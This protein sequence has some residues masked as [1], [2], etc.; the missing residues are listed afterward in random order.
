MPVP[1]YVR[2][3][4]CVRVRVCVCGRENSSNDW[5]KHRD[6]QAHHLNVPC[7]LV[8]PPF[9]HLLPT[10]CLCS[11]PAKA[12]QVWTKLRNV[13]AVGDAKKRPVVSAMAARFPNADA[14]K[15]HSAAAAPKA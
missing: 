9:Q 12:E 13:Q 3:C 4:V 10:A 2:L 6:N 14:F 11:T 1:A 5:H 15:L 8:V 7:L